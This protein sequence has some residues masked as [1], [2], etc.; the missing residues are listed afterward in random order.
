MIYCDGIC[1]G[2]IGMK[3][4]IFPCKVMWWIMWC[5]SMYAWYIHEICYGA[6]EKGNEINVIL[7]IK[8]M[9]PRACMYV[10]CIGILPRY[11]ILVR[12]HTFDIYVWHVIMKTFSFMRVQWHIWCCAQQSLA[13]GARIPIRVMGPCMHTWA[14][15]R[16]VPCIQLCQEL[17]KA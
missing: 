11:V 2:M 8:I 14:V 10:M 9:G 17:K 4:Y 3:C 16:K 13:W 15:C 1:Y 7:W 5:L 6:K 12:M